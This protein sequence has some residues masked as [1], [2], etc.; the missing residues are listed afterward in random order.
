[1]SAGHSIFESLGIAAEHSHVASAVTVLGALSL[2]GIG[3]RA[4]LSKPEVGVLPDKGFSLLN[5]STS[6]VQAF[7]NLLDNMIGHGAE[8]YVPIVGTTF[9]FILVSNLAGM[10]PM[11]PPPTQNLNTNLAMGLIVFVL[12]QFLGFKEHGIGYLK[13]FTGGLP[14]KGYGVI[15]T[16]VLS[17]IA[18]LMF[19]IELIGHMIRPVSLSL[20]LWGNINGD[21]TLVG[22]FLGLIP[23]FVP[24]LAMVL[25]VFVCVIQSLVFSLLSAVYIKL[26]VSHDH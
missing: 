17:G 11:F 19:V 8:K 21:H 7:K 5:V 14:P 2:M 3:V 6:L 13:Q 15:M 12:Y 16:L 18:C 10:F 26:A 4:R 23:L 25:G 1:M 24:I 9:L 20:R 22:V